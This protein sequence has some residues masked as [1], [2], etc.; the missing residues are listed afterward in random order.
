[1]AMR[2]VMGDEP[3]HRQAL[4]QVCCAGRDVLGR[5]SSLEALECGPGN[6]MTYV[7][8][9]GP[10]D[11]KIA[12]LRPMME[13]D[14]DLSAVSAVADVSSADGRQQCLSNG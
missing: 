7:Q 4:G 11:R 10:K 8:L 9:I 1:M 14:V 6:D 5:T 12:W 2:R 3:G 13:Q